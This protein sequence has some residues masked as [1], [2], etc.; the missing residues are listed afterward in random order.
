MPL[1]WS[2]FGTRRWRAH[3]AEL[4]GRVF[5]KE[6]E[7]MEWLGI[8]VG[9]FNEAGSNLLVVSERMLKEVVTSLE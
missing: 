2:A 6:S 3:V 7:Y 4:A 8:G 1:S 9:L 5:R